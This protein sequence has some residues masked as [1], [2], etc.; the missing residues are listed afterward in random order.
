MEKHEH[1]ELLRKAIDESREWDRQ[2]IATAFGRNYR[3]IS[4]WISETKPTMPSGEERA[5]LRRMLGPY[6]S[7][8]DGV[9]RAIDRSDLVEWRR[10]AVKSFYKRNLHEQRGEATG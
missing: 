3:T 4:N 7:P 1:A 9:E 8:G 2:S 5:Q 6:D 10:D